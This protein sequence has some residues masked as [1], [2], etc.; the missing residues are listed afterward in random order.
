MNDSIIKLKLDFAG[1][2]SGNPL[3]IWLK[4][5]EIFF[6]NLNSMITRKIVQN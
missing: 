3:T 5:I 1:V 4:I 6:S 2:I